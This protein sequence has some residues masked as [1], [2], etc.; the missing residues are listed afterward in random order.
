[1][2]VPQGGG[3][4]GFN[5]FLAYYPGSK[6]TVAVLANLN[7]QAPPQIRAIWRSWPTAAWCG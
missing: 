1:M 4:E 7:G 3:I 2:S 6:M 5:T